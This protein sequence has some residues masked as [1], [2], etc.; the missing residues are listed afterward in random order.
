MNISQRYTEQVARFVVETRVDTI[1][2]EVAAEAKTAPDCLV[3]A[4]AGRKEEGRA[5]A[6][7]VL[8]EGALGSHRLGTGIQS[9]RFWRR[10]PMEGAH[11]LDFDHGVY[12]PA[13]V[14]GHSRCRLVGGSSER[15]RA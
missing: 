14:G 5:S 8:I 7:Q 4:L 1:P 2:R 11:A 10:S 6:R 9:S 15:K 13:Y 3:V 12:R